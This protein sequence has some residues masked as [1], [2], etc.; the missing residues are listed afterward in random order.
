MIKKLLLVAVIGV[1]AF[2]ALRGTKFFGLAKQEIAVAQTWL[3]SQVPVE[4]EIQRLRKE[5]VNLDKDRGKV[6]DLLA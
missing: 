6:G 4:K 5:V 1:A 3:D 2:A